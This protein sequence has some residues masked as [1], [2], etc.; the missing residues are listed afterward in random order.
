VNR[1]RRQAGARRPRGSDAGPLERLRAICLALPE[2]TEKIAWSEP[3]FRVQGKLFAQFDNHHHGAEH[4][5]VWLPMPLGAQESLVYTDPR[6]YFVPPYV[7]GRGWVGVRLD[8]RPN[9]NAVRKLVGEAYRCV[10]PP[11][12]V[13]VAP[14]M[15]R[16]VSKG[17][18]ADPV[19]GKRGLRPS[20]LS[21]LLLIVGIV[22]GA[23]F[24]AQAA[25]PALPYGINAHLP[26]SSVLDLVRDA[27]IAWIRV[28]F[29]WN[30]M[31]PDRGAYDWSVTDQVVSDARARGIN[32]FATLAYTPGWANGGQYINV[33][34][35]DS[36]DWYQFVFDTVSRY[37]DDIK[38]WGMWNE[39]N[40]HS[41]F[42]GS[43][44]QYVQDVLRVGAKAVRDADPG[45]LV[46]GP[47]LAQLQSDQC[48]AWLFTVLTQA[49]DVIDIV[50]HHDYGGTGTSTI[51]GI[52]VEG[53]PQR[54][55]TARGIMSI[56][57]TSDKPLWLTETGWRT[58]E[59]TQ[60]QQ[61]DYYEQVL[62]GLTANPT[63]LDEV[64]FYEM[65]DD[66]RFPNQW[67]IVQA[68]LTPKEAYFRY[69]DYITAHPA[70]P[71]AWPVP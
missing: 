10:A 11:R 55:R 65:A 45:G 50:T 12:L 9:W 43:R 44:Q 6:R 40:V 53:A 52:G 70:A 37:K 20:R 58:D 36:T 7:G 1:S 8:G 56:T 34:A 59:V 42:I 27:G 18:R 13:A 48:A 39:P 17:K 35:I 67:G 64:F 24:P 57:G 61:A 69:Q 14:G 29:N 16:S 60:T 51:K 63:L 3:T 47:E 2:A 4:V 19:R 54:I 5:G 38:H 49:G 15:A 41:F 66:P 31:E 21:R 23:W 71:A 26:S 32:I 46:L 25:D 68:D 62:D 28:D 30:L 22:A 33:P